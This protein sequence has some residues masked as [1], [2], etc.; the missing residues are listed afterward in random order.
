MKLAGKELGKLVAKQ[1]QVGFHR[2][3]D[4]DCPV[5]G[6]LLDYSDEWLLV[7][8]VV[9]F[10][11]DGYTLLRPKDVCRIRRRARMCDRLLRAEGVTKE[12][13][14]AGLTLDLKT[15]EFLLKDLKA[16]AE[17]IIVDCEY[18]SEDAYLYIGR[19][20]RVGKLSV[21]MRWFDVNAR[22]QPECVKVPYSAI[23]TIRFDCEYS[24]VYSKYLQKRGT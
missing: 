10:H 9:D 6:Y 19:P 23:S 17:I 16:R 15:T 4:A 3:G 2:L 13:I 18:S 7:R 22:W 21:S 14:F 24:H 8:C 5:E 12:D 1:R 20:K 11:L